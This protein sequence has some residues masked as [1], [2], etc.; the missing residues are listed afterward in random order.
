MCSFLKKDCCNFIESK[1]HERP[2]ICV[3]LYI[4]LIVKLKWKAILFETP[5]YL[6]GIRV[7]AI[8][9]CFHLRKKTI[10]VYVPQSARYFFFASGERVQAFYDHLQHSRRI[11]C[12]GIVTFFCLTQTQCYLEIHNLLF[13]R[14]GLW[15]AF[16]E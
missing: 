12:Y 9:K 1:R 11:F 16:S 5:V 13:L 15:R 8:D 10:I 14:K 7:R 6:W 2:E 4:K 3:K